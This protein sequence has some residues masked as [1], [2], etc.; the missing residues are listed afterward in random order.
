MNLSTYRWFYRFLLWQLLDCFRYWHGTSLSTIYCNSVLVQSVHSDPA[1]TTSSMFLVF[2]DPTNTILILGSKF[3]QSLERKSFFTD[4]SVALLYFLWGV[5]FSSTKNELLSYWTV[6][7][8]VS[9]MWICC[10]WSLETNKTR[11][12]LLPSWQRTKLPSIHLVISFSRRSERR[13]PRLQ[14]VHMLF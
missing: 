8:L 6:D 11:W 9:K 14:Q 1:M 4:I 7:E 3:L 2:V 13:M 12:S 5:Y 10:L